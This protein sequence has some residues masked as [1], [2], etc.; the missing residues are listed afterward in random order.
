MMR[1]RDLV[2]LYW[3]VEL[4]PAFDALFDLE[5]AMAD[6]VATSTQPALGAIRL[7]WWREALERLD[8]SPAPAEPRLQAIAAE[9]L[10]R[11]LSGARLAAIE[12][13][14]AALL[15][16]EPDIQ[17][18]M[19]GGAALFACAAMLLDVDDPLLPQAGAAHAVA[20]AMRGG[21]LA[22]ATVHNYLKCV[23]FAKPLRPLTAFTR[24]AQRDRR[25]F[26][27]VEPEATPGRA[28]ALLSHRLFGTVA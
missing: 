13:G 9:L 20:R 18:V 16:G 27:A 2:R 24:L 26:P 5:Q 17:R 10:P 11:G 6:V 1:D 22:S 7:A 8:T 21:L 19:K 12:D 15:D 23:R 14:F 28:A 3:P 4:R 25:Q